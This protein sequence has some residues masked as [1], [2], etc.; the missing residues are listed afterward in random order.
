MLV[1]YGEDTSTSTAPTMQAD[2]L[3]TTAGAVAAW[4]RVVAVRVGLMMVTS[5]ATAGIEVTQTTPTLLGQSYTVPTG[6]GNV[7]R[8]EFSTTIVLRNRVLPR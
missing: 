8:K 1:H 7:I 6:T 5:D 2:T 3:R 4:S